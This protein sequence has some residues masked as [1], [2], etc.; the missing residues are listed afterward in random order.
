[1]APPA[2]VDDVPVVSE[3]PSL[4]DPSLEDPSLEEPPPLPSLLLPSLLALSPLMLPMK[5]SPLLP[6]V[7]PSPP[8][9]SE[10]P[11][12]PHAD[13]ASPTPAKSIRAVVMDEI[14]GD[15][16]MK[17]WVASSAVGSQSS[18]GLPERE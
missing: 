18:C 5:A 12:P 1:V 17:G 10:S 14:L 8:P 2:P 4:E 15:L 16:V 3:L 6:L 11:L 9:E 7:P 13:T